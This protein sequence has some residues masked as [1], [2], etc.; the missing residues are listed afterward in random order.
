MFDLLTNAD[1]VISMVLLCRFGF[2]CLLE[3]RVE[4][5]VGLSA[6]LFWVRRDREGSGNE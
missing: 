4:E 1:T 3:V 5:E 2:W 6:W